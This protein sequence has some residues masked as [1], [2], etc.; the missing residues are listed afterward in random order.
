MY[1]IVKLLGGD[2]VKLLGRIYPPIPRVSALLNEN[3]LRTRRR[4]SIVC[5]RL[6]WTAPY[7]IMC[8]Y[9]FFLEKNTTSK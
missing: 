7:E 3:N 6:L 9:K 1:T 4:G 8:C 5:E 2:A